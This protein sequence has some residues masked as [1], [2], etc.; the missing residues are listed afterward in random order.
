MTIK[1]VT[2]FGTGNFGA[3]LAFHIAFN[4]VDVT[5]Y[6]RDHGLLEEARTKFREFGANYHERFRASTED[7]KAALANI[8]YSTKVSEAAGNANLIIE[9]VAE[10]LQAKTNFYSELRETAPENTIFASTS[11]SIDPEVLAKASGRAD[12]FVVLHFEE[13]NKAFLS[14]KI[15]ALSSVRQEIVDT[16]TEFSENTGIE[17][18]TVHPEKQNKKA[19]I[20]PGH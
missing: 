6:D 18:T 12:R 2:V 10:D 15:V 1:K 20:E 19:R 13:E 7:V 17:V 14:L 16:I 4:K 3:R 5:V 9:A 8:A 11:Q